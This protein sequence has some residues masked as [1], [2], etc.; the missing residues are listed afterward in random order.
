MK[1]KIEEL[2]YSDID[3]LVDLFV[4]VWK[5]DRKKIM[6]KTNWAFNNNF[7][8]VLVYE[9][10]RG[11]F[12][13]ARGAIRWPL[14]LNGLEYNC[15]QFHNTCVH[16]DYRR[17]GLFTKLNMEFLKLCKSENV[18]LIF[19]I[20]LDASRAG[21]EKLGWKY[22]NGFHRLTK[23]HLT[24]KLFSIFNKNEA[25][26]NT[27]TI[28][29]NL[30][31]IKNKEFKNVVHTFYNK[32]YMSWRLS[33]VEEKYKIFSIRNNSIIY[34]IKFFQNMKTLIIGEI[35]LEQRTYSEFSNILNSLIKYENPVM[36][37][38][39]I[40]ESH[41]YYR[42]FLRFLYFPNFLN[43]NLN[44]GIRIIND[45]I[46]LHDSNWGLTTLDLDTF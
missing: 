22:F 15:Y 21:Y 26:F 30:L 3:K 24:N 40:F 38:L 4:L 5:N 28:K 41:P 2:Q 32:T 42:Y 17:R 13:A 14:M 23:I 39:Y 11:E 34:K 8:K 25:K 19:N 18:D 43:Y 46:N 6:E 16:P 1:L 37:Y 44:F 31:F 27:S 12:V 7:S 45:Q 33:N 29:G 20:S 10:E 9:N 35:F 36:S